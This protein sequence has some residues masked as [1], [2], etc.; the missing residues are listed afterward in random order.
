MKDDIILISGFMGA[1]KTTFGRKLASDKGYAFIDLDSYI[2][3][4]ESKSIKDIFAEKGEAHFRELE[5]ITFA[6]II[7]NTTEK[8]VIALGG[9]FPIKPE[10]RELMKAHTTIF[11][12]TPLEKIIERLN[13]SEIAKRPMLNDD[14]ERLKELYRKRLPIYLKTADIISS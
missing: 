1:G 13:K 9:G 6:E 8:T 7:K 5:T 14:I 4:H 12:N 3:E 10:N 11:L 2:E